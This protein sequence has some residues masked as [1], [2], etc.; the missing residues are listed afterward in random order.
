MSKPIEVLIVEDDIRIAEIHRR[1]T[2]K[3]EGFSVIA[4]AT[5]GEQAREWLEVV[6]PQL[7]LLDVYLPDMRGIDLVPVIRQNFQHTDVIMITAASEVEVVRKALH[8]GVFDYIVKPLTFDRFRAS[9]EK[10]RSHLQRLEETE[11]L[12]AQ[13]IEELWKKEQSLS[14]QEEEEEDIPKGIDPLTLDRILRFVAQMED[15]G[16]TAEML[17][18]ESGVSRSTA[19]RYLE[20]L[21]SQKKIYAELIYGNVGRP[22]RRYFRSHS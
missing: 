12:S 1:F 4:T 18:K 17:S 11:T 16:M 14:F 6:G 7:V 13:Q 2:E 9:L 8:G 19:R 20:Y 22:E 21:I 15:K 3:V 10:Y 5:T